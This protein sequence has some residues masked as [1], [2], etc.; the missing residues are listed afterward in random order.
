MATSRKQSEATHK[1]ACRLIRNCWIRSVRS[2][3][4]RRARME[5]V[6]TVE[7]TEAAMAA[8]SRAHLMALLSPNTARLPSRLASSESSWRTP[9]QPSKS[10]N[11]SR[12]RKPLPEATHRARRASEESHPKCQHQA[13]TTEPHPVRRATTAHLSKCIV[14][15]RTCHIQNTTTAYQTTCTTPHT[16]MR[17]R[18]ID[19]AS[20][21]LIRSNI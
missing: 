15:S 14:S 13:R 18:S 8:A 19:R 9:S 6:R 7:D 20:P 10:P 21:D 1:K 4:V 2:C 16:D 3:C 17:R 5:A 11:T 12:S